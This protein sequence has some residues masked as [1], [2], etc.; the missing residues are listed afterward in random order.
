MRSKKNTSF[1]KI[2]EVGSNEQWD[3]YTVAMLFIGNF[4]DFNNNNKF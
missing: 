3:F 2:S 1:C 4:N